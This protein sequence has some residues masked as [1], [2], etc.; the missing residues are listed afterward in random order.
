MRVLVPIA[1]H[2]MNI[3]FADGTDVSLILY[4]HIVGH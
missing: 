1:N 3:I 2:N 4:T